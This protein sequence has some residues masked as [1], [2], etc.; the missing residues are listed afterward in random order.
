M[1]HPRDALTQRAGVFR[2]QE[3]DQRLI[4]GVPSDV[5]I[6]YFLLLLLGL[7]G[8]PISRAW[9]QRLWP[10]ELAS[11]YEGR[12]GYWAARA[13]RGGAFLLLFLPLTAPITAPLN[14]WRQFANAATAPLRWWRW[15]AQRR[16][17]ENVG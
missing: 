17:A 12:A 5:Q 14:L 15:L 4:P 13:V 3:L 11:E 16:T 7:V 9:W 2:Q 10:P 1:A 8:V 6:G